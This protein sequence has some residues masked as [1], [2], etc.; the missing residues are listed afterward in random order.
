MASRPYSRK[1]LYL[2]PCS[3]LHC[4]SIS[5]PPFKVG[6]LVWFPAK[7]EP[8][9]RA[10]MQVA[11]LKRKVVEVYANL[12]QG[13]NKYYPHPLPPKLNRVEEQSQNCLPQW[14]FQ[15]SSKELVSDKAL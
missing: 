10:L 9:T 7:A 3:S 6:K 12:V 15:F 2:E 1:I 11:F 5:Y 8:E 13:L 4:L 14:P